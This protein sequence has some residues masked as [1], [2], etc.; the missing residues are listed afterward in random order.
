M[1]KMGCFSGRIQNVPK[2]VGGTLG[3]DGKMRTGKPL[4]NSWGD[5]QISTDNPIWP[6]PFGEQIAGANDVQT[7]PKYKDMPILHPLRFE[8]C[9]CRS[10][11]TQNFQGSGWVARFASKLSTLI[12]RG[13]CLALCRSGF[14]RRNRSGPVQGFLPMELNFNGN[15]ASC[16]GSSIMSAEGSPNKKNHPTGYGE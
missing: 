5:T 16:S 6:C 8:I 15:R 12:P 2:S 1:L 4:S 13:Q 14:V 11:D 7:H 3:P 9:V 10:K